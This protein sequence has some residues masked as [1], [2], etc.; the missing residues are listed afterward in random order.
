MTVEHELDQMIAAV[1]LSVKNNGRIQLVHS[2]RSEQMLRILKFY[3]AH[4]DELHKR[5]YAENYE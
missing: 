5:A 2:H 3:R 4:W 1:E